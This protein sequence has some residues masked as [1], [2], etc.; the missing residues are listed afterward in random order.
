MRLKTVVAAL[1]LSL[2]C[3]VSRA[4]FADTLQ[5]TGTPGQAVDGLYVY[6]YSMT[7]TGPGGTNT[8]VSMSCLNFNRE[9][10]VGQQ[11]W[12]VNVYSVAGIAPGA[13]IDG[14]LGIDILADAYLYN[15]YA[16]ANAQLTSDI[17]FAIWYIMDPT[18]FTVVNGVPNYSGFDTNAQALASAALTVAN[19]SNLNT[20]QFANDYL[21]IPT[22][23]TGGEPQEFMTNPAPLAVTPEPTS[24]LLLGTGMFGASL[25]LH[26]RPVLVANGRK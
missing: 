25:L 16:G 6:P 3:L 26:R 4:S 19:S 18:A 17:Q 5:L 2:V 14:E 24:L 11:P 8:L 13:T 15:Q 7:V 20:S 1:T 9:V 10:T 23:Y 12:N 21:F 22:G